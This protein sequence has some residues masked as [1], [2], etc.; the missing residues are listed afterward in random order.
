VSL[1]LIIYFKG[2]VAAA[3]L[4]CHEVVV[5]F[6][7]IHGDAHVV[8][9]FIKTLN[10]N[11]PHFIQETIRKLYGEELQSKS[12]EQMIYFDLYLSNLKLSL[13]KVFDPEFRSGQLSLK[14]KEVLKSQHKLL[15]AGVGSNQKNYNGFMSGNPGKLD[16]SAGVMLHEQ[17]MGQLMTAKLVLRGAGVPEINLE[18]PFPPRIRMNGIDEK[19]RAMGLE[20]E[21][22][23][24]AFAGNYFPKNYTDQSGRVIHEYPR[25]FSHIQNVYLERMA[26]VLGHIENCLLRPHPDTPIK[27]V[28]ALIAEYYHVGINAHLFEHGNNSMLMSQVNYFL[29]YLGLKGI[30]HQYWDYVAL[31]N[32]SEEF[33]KIF[34]AAIREVNPEI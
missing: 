1:V 26:F 2:Q 15:I 19:V 25:F 11:E 7:G 5:S 16:V 4:F 6:N 28:L 31:I 22:F 18:G 33:E 23:Q 34:I 14:L 9:V 27:N 30:R 13:E 3:D 21:D 17:S 32:H 20:P 8:P 29:H 12:A 10:I 24:N